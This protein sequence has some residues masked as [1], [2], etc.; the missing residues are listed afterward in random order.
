M[1]KKPGIFFLLL[2]T[3]LSVSGIASGKPVPVVPEKTEQSQVI[4]H[5]QQP[6]AEL[7]REQV[8]HA[9]FYHASLKKNHILPGQTYGTGL[10]VTKGLSFCSVNPKSVPAEKAYLFHIH[11]THN[12]W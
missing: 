8:T 4:E 2:I 5:R 10:P 9:F 7:E 12:H 3:I 11:P 6:N 1:R